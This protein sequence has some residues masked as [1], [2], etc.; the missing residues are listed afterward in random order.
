MKRKPAVL[1][2]ARERGSWKGIAVTALGITVGMLL[3][4]LVISLLIYLFVWLS[5]WCNASDSG[6]SNDPVPQKAEILPVSSVNYN[7]YINGNLVDC[8]DGY[9]A[10]YQYGVIRNTL[11]QGRIKGGTAWYEKIQNSS[12]APPLDIDGFGCIS[13]C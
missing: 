12:E 10:L 13:L 4:I 9:L 5:G 7:N 11:S 3:A 1:L 6:H 8:R 2:E